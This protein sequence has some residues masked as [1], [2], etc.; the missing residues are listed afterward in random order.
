MKLDIRTKIRLATEL[1]VLASGNF[2][3]QAK[4]GEFVLILPGPGGMEPS[5]PAVVTRVQEFWDE[6]NGQHIRALQV[7]D[8]DNPGSDQEGKPNWNMQLGYDYETS[9]RLG[10]DL[11]R[12]LRPVE[13]I[14]IPD[15]FDLLA[16]LRKNVD[17]NPEILIVDEGI[18]MRTGKEK[19]LIAQHGTEP[20]VVPLVAAAAECMRSILKK[21][22]AT[23]EVAPEPP[24][25][26]GKEQK[27]KFTR[28]ES[29]GK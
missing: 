27:P 1:K 3:M 16:F 15:P 18:L 20:I 6:Q 11:K 13:T 17:G 4:V 10:M 8:P 19:H 26:P 5:G 2:P 21:A 25:D 29:N 28:S 12:S 24:A 22:E 7:F 14:R 23:Q 9:W